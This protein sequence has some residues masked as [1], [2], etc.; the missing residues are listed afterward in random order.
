M[1][2]KLF[3]ISTLAILAAAS[4]TATNGGGDSDDLCC[5]SVSKASDPAAAG[6]LKS[7]GAVV[8][9]ADVLVGLTCSPITVI[10]VGSGNTW[11][12]VACS[13]GVEEAFLLM[14]CPQ[15]FRHHRQL[16]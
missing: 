8:Q 12:V 15:R 9:G 13:L 4:P 2:S 7:I 10:G 1:F 11:Y 6:I 14:L 3:A 5:T 16:Y